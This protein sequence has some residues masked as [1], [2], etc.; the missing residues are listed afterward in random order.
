VETVVSGIPN[1]RYVR[2]VGLG[3]VDPS[4][5]EVRTVIPSGAVWRYLADGND[6]ENDWK[7]LPFDASGWAQGPAQLGYGDG[8]EATVVSFGGDPN[9][10]YPTSYFRHE[11]YL[12]AAEIS[13]LD[14]V[15]G[16]LLRDDGAAVYVNGVE[17][18]RDASLRPGAG[19]LELANFNGAAA[20]GGTDENVWNVVAIDQS[21]LR[22]GFNV[23]GVEVHQHAGNSSDVSFDFELRARFAVVPEPSSLVLAIL[24]TLGALGAIRRRRVGR[25][26]RA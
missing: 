8:D 17:V 25:A 15:F 23:I 19:Y 11:F 13:L 5:F 6:Q 16:S 20:I 1:V 10:K 22:E 7:E 14:S 2:L 4:P 9:N 18:Y 24:G 21:L 26:W 12:D 3:N